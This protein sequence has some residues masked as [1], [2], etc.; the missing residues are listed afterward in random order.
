MTL[1]PIKAAV[2]PYALLIKCGLALL[3]AASLFIGGCNHGAGKW[4]AKYD[5]E[6]RAHEADEIDNEA[7]LDALSNRA[8][9]AEAAAKE[10]GAQAAREREAADDQFNKSKQ[11]S[12]HEIAGLRAALRRGTVQL[13]PEFACPAARPAE[14][15]TPAASGRQDGEAD[16][17][18][19]REGAILDDIADHDAADRW[20]EWLQ[21]DAVATR[22][23]CGVVP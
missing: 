3:L 10:A 18:R 7:L 17:R 9:A 19:T 8:K 11:E 22:K 15:E 20:I 5:D 16:L 14:G 13:R 12:D 23:A 1:D 6:V 21:A 2:A 4:K